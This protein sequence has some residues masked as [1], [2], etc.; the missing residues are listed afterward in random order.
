MELGPALF[1]VP[2]SRCPTLHMPGILIRVTSIDSARGIP[3]GGAFETSGMR[4][5]YRK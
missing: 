2:P 1:Q 3:Y 4:L 5:I